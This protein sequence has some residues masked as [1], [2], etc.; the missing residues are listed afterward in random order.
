MGW[1]SSLILAD[2]FEGW[3]G[4][5][6]KQVGSVINTSFILQRDVTVA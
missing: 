3:G 4:K 1:V 2:S 5:R 6:A